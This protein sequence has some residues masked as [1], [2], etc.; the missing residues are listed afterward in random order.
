MTFD[1]SIDSVPQLLDQ[2]EIGRHRWPWKDVNVT[3]CK[4]VSCQDGSVWVCVVMLKCYI[5]VI[6]LDKGDKM[7]S[8]AFFYVQIGCEIPMHKH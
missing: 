7:G 4:E 1:V 6:L 2:V 3:L 8:K 5:V